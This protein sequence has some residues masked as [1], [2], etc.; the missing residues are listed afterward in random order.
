MYILI[1]DHNYLQICL[2]TTKCNPTGQKKCM[3]K[4][5]IVILFGCWMMMLFSLNEY[6]LIWLNCLNQY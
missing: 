1:A 3:G 2:M 5:I 4:V 6:F